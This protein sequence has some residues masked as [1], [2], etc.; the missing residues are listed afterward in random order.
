MAFF[1]RC[2]TLIPTWIF[3]VPVSYEGQ[4]RCPFFVSRLLT[5]HVNRIVC[6]NSPER[7]QIPAR[8]PLFLKS[9]ANLKPSLTIAHFFCFVLHICADICSTYYFVIIS[10]DMTPLQ[11]NPA[12]FCLPRLPIRQVVGHQCLE[13]S[14]MIEDV[15]M[16]QFMDNY[17]LRQWCRD[18]A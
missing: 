15:Q 10:R 6:E 14:T 3:R 16:H 8:F 11:R 13:F 5:L 4:I 2:A 1:G 17:I 18:K 9:Y 12:Q 7:N